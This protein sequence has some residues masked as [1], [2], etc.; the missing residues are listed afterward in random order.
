MIIIFFSYFLSFQY[1]I[2]DIINDNNDIGID[3]FLKEKKKKKIILFFYFW[4]NNNN[5]KIKRKSS[6]GIGDDN[7][8]IEF[9]MWQS[10]FIFIFGKIML[11]KW[12]IKIIYDYHMKWYEKENY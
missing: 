8:E 12:F 2:N 11:T 1:K 4:M 5:N 7:I 6:E 3:F 9:N 10:K